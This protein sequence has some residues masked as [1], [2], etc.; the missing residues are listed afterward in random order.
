RNPLPANRLG[1]GTAP[2]CLTVC[3]GLPTVGPASGAPESSR[4]TRAVDGKR[5]DATYADPGS[6]LERLLRRPP[7][8]GA[9]AVF[10]FRPQ[11]EEA[12]T[13]GHADGAGGEHRGADRRV[14]EGRR[15]GESRG[16]G[17][18][19]RVGLFLRRRRQGHGAPGGVS[20]Y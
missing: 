6:A 13:Y 7:W 17:G 4:L 1:A 16:A 19:R 18:D 8:A 20:I 9:R 14:G 15:D 3:G 10:R 5:L 2:P 11:L 12:G